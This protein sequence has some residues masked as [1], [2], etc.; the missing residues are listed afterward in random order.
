MD[1]GALACDDPS[2]SWT[3]DEGDERLANR[4]GTFFIR[5]SWPILGLGSIPAFLIS[6]F[7]GP[8]DRG[9]LIGGGFAALVAMP[10]YA[11]LVARPLRWVW[12]GA[13]GLRVSDGRREVRVP[14]SSI[15]DVR[16]FWYARDLVRVTLKAPTAVGSRFIF[17]PS[18][19]WSTRGDHPVVAR[20]RERAGIVAG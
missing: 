14:Y 4:W 2:M 12:A 1:R 6:L 19:R 18:W 20:L 10:A 3:A 17:I 11:W 16:G 8:S 15:E 7:L 5:L 9:F 13:D